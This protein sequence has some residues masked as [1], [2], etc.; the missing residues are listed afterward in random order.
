MREFDDYLA[1]SFDCYG[2]LIDWE[3]GI[4]AA[5]RP[6]A[7]RHRLGMDDDELVAAFGA[8]ETVVEGE[9]PGAAYPEVL[10]EVLRRIGAEHGVKVSEAD[11]TAF[12]GS[13]GDWPAFPDSAEA[14]ARL[15]ERYRLLILSN[16]DRR[17][18]A[19]SNRRLG[20]T[21]DRIITAEDVGSYKPDPANFAALLDAVAADG[22][23][24]TRLLH[25]AESLYHDHEPAAAAGIDSVWIHRRFDRDGH[26]ATHPPLTEVTPRWRFTSLAAFADTALD[27]TE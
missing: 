7:D 24:R 2:T 15:G 10:A 5:M 6:W 19:A 12:G 25:V 11:A 23:D 26:G 4:A 3:T 14:L 22:I 20:V 21:F 18:F 13:V 9:D 16:V 1:L 8:V 17:S 27:P